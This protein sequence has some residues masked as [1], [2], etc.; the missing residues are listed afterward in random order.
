MARQLALCC[1][2]ALQALYDE[3]PRL[4]RERHGRIVIF[5]DL[6]LGDGSSRDDFRPNSE[7]FHRVLKENY[8]ERDYSLVLNG[9]IEELQRYRLDRIMAAWPELYDTFFEF[10]RQERLFKLA[11]N[12]D[13]DLYLNRVPEYPFPIYPALRIN[14]GSK[15]LFIF[16]G[17]QASNYF[18]QLNQVAGFLIRVFVHPVGIKNRSAAH[19][20]RKRYR[21]ENRIYDFA[22]KRKL[23][24]VIGHTHRPLF[25]SLSKT[26][27]LKYHI[28]R[29]CRNYPGAI[30]GARRRIESQIMQYR[31]E[32]EEIS[33]KQRSRF[34][35]RRSRSET[36][37]DR[38]YNRELTVPCLF[39]SG[40]VIGKRGLTAIEI[41]GEMVR[42]VHWFDAQRSKKYFSYN[43]YQP[44]PLDEDQRF[45]R[46][47][48]KED[49]LSY[50]EARITL[51]A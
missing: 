50:L 23:I 32:L 39:N 10:H 31:N 3:A 1:E 12:H 44:E 22:R 40:C 4:K 6:H 38:L 28:E 7:L 17:H 13:F 29:L 46:V 49:N 18:A 26:E 8:L 14:G 36:L 24:A 34:S 47:I 43:G 51:L 45:Y 16:H 9:D 19:K 41:E 5:S 20:V 33:S 42:L 2:D 30:N 35:P 25:E 15:E 48:L 37:A 21:I 27:S 11:G